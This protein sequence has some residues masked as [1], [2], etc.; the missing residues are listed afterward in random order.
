MSL[1]ATDAKGYERRET[2]SLVVAASDRLAA[3]SNPITVIGVADSGINA[4]HLE[5]SA[6]TYPDPE[7]LKLTRNFT[8]H[9]SEYIPGYPEDAQAIPISLGQGYYPAK[10]QAV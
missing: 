1:K 3:E 10:D 6:Q 8:A 9:P 2:T 4:Y 5:F 7:I